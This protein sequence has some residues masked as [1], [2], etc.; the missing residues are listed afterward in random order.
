MGP[1]A[2]ESHWASSGNGELMACVEFSI[3]D[4]IQSLTT[5]IE[6]DDGKILTGKPFFLFLKPMVSGVQIFP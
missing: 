4:G 5:V 3:P 6:L 2:M 1:P